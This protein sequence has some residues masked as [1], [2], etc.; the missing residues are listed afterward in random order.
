MAVRHGVRT[1]GAFDVGIR[2]EGDWLRF[3]QMVGSIDLNLMLAAKSAQ[4]KFAEEY[5]DRVKTNIRTG[6]KRFGYPGHSVKYKQYKTR[7]GGPA[8]LFYWSGAMH[9]AVGIMGLPGGRLGIGIPRGL[10]RVP[11]HS[12]EGELLTISEYANILEHGAWSMG[13]PARPIFADTFKRDMKGMAGLKSFLQF[14]LIRNLK[15]KGINITP[16]I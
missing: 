3:N 8:R 12:H 10:M 9:N 7:Y 14:H 4:R 13:I 15:R 5:R 6:G 11:Y 1:R 16:I 2:L